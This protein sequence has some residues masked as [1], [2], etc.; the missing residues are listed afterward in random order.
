MNASDRDGLTA[1]HAA[2]LSNRNT[3][4][5]RALLDGGADT[6]A[7]SHAGTSPLLAA[8]FL[9][10]AEVVAWLFALGADASLSD[11]TGRRALDNGRL[12]LCASSVGT[13]L[14][15]ATNRQSGQRRLAS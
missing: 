9:N 14:I 3:A 8:A 7:Q 4:V 2:A 5:L 6:N 11:E 15:H 10:S 12:D 1:L 13:A